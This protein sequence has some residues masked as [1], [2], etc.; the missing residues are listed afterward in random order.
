VSWRSD[1][2]PD[3][4]PIAVFRYVVG[5]AGP[6]TGALKVGISGRQAPVNQRISLT[7]DHEA[8]TDDEAL[9]V[10]IT[11]KLKS[12]ALPRDTQPRM[13]G[14]PGIGQKCDAC[15]EVISANQLAMAVPLQP[16]RGFLFLHA[17]CFS[18]WD[19]ERRTLPAGGDG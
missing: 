5:C 18:M 19:A 8:V 15:E 11:R 6:N 10:L 17:G 16:K 12:G 1:E 3:R 4:E 13:F 14:A 2:N 9:R 7:V